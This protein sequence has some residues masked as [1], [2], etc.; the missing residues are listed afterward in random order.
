MPVPETYEAVIGNADD[1]GIEV[2]VIRDVH[3]GVDGPWLTEPVPARAGMTPEDLIAAAQVV[4]ARHGV[5][6]TG[7]WRAR[8]RAGGGE[9]L[10]AAVHPD[11]PTAPP[12]TTAGAGRRRGHLRAVR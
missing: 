5:A 12:S 3:A 9:Q 1:G 7:P 10:V 8:L 6:V 4:L 11:H 2:T